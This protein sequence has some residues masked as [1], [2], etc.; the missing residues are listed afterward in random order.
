M[1]TDPAPA[2]QHTHKHPA[3]QARSS[4]SLPRL[5]DAHCILSLFSCKPQVAPYVAGSLHLTSSASAN[6]TFKADPEPTICPGSH[7]LGPRSLPCTEVAHQPPGSAAA[8]HSPPHAHLR[9]PLKMQVEGFSSAQHLQELPT[10]SE[11]KREP[12]Q[13]P[14]G[15]RP[16]AFCQFQPLGPLV[17]P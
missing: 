8:Q 6:P 11:W 5:S 9:A 3:L 10:Y 14:K 2:P 16:S 15:P 12:L 13:C 1:D 17:T 7:C 4:H